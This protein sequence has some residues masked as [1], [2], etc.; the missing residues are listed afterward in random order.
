MRRCLLALAAATT[1]ASAAPAQAPGAI[2]PDGTVNVPGFAL[3]PSAYMSEAAKKALPRTPTDPEEAMFKVLASGRAG[4]VRKQLPRLMA[5]RV[6]H[7]TELYPVTM[8]TTEIAG[9]PAVIATP[10]GPIPPANRKKI[11]LNLPG[12]GFVMGEAG[13]TGMVESIPL[14]AMAKVEVV[15]IT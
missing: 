6:R 11:L 12:G 4:E 1:L 10:A 13:S 7:L 14:V 8:R 2:E 3:P 5:A 9:V 15:S